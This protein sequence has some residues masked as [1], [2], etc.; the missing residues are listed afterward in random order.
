ML[1]HILEGRREPV[2]DDSRGGPRRESGGPRRHPP[3]IRRFHVSYICPFLSF[4]FPHPPPFLS[5]PFTTSPCLSSCLIFL[6]WE[7]ALPCSSAQ[8]VG[9]PV[10]L[11]AKGCEVVTESESLP[12]EEVAVCE[13]FASCLSP[14]ELGRHGP[15]SPPDALPLPSCISGH[16]CPAG[17][18]Q[19]PSRVV[20]LGRRGSVVTN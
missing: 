20:R 3:C 6:K 1:L 14:T 13:H 17:W 15:K 10:L 7:G 8:P 4:C 11:R 9:S 5:L 16:S 12:P 19:W 2:V 18:Q